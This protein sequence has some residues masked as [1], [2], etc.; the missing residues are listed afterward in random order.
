MLLSMPSMYLLSIYH[1]GTEKAHTVTKEVTVLTST[2]FN[3]NPSPL[4]PA[5]DPEA[6]HVNGENIA[7]DK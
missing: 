6:K 3:S 2:P 7:I 1:V 4:S 5:F